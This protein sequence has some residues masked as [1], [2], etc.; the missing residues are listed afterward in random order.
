LLFEGLWFASYR[1]VDF[2]FTTVAILAIPYIGPTTGADRM[3]YLEAAL[4][5]LTAA[6]NLLAAWL[7]SQWVYGIGPLDAL[8]NFAGRFVRRT[9]V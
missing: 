4:Y 8:S 1:V 3:M 9:H 2:V 5:L 6:L 7:L